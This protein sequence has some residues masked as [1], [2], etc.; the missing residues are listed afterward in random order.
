MQIRECVVSKYI[1]TP[2]HKG[3]FGLK[4]RIPSGVPVLVELHVHVCF[5][6]IALFAVGMDFLR[7]HAIN[8]K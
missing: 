2:L 6:P 8:E 4:T 1:L 5:I 7:N 3:I